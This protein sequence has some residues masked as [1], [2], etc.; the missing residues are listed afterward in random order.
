MRNHISHIFTGA[1]LGGVVSSVAVANFPL[2]TCAL[3]LGAVGCLLNSGTENRG[4]KA[5][6]FFSAMVVAGALIFAG[7][8]AGGGQNSMHS[9]YS[10]STTDKKVTMV[11]ETPIP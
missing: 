6:S 2:V 10:D 8:N 11:V 7:Q 5:G 9:L 1:S 4:F 3:L